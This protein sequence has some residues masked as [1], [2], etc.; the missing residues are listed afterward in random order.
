MD[1][2]ILERWV[3][4]LRSMQLAVLGVEAHLSRIQCAL[5]QGGLDQA[6]PLSEFHQEIEDC[7][8]LA[9]KMAARPT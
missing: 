8:D 1:Q 2:N 3:G 9:A 7:N 4:K 5:A 6:W